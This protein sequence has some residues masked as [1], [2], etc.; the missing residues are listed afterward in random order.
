MPF[1]SPQV[2][3]AVTALV[4][5]LLLAATVF[6]PLGTLAWSHEYTVEQVKSDDPQLGETLAWTEQATS[7]YAENEA[8]ELFYSLKDNESQ[9][10][11]DTT[12]RAAQG[13]DQE[14]EL[15]IFPNSTQKFYQLQ[16]TPYENESIRVDL[17]SISDTTA[18]ELA[19]TPSSD[20]PQGVQN[21]VE[22]GQVRTDE[23]LSGYALWSHTRDIIA[24]DGTYYRQDSFTYRGPMFGGTDFH[25]LVILAVGAAL[26][27]RAGRVE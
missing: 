7:C 14:T 11:A 2:R 16:L 3:R 10:V 20:Y 5:L 1:D 25:R 17:T 9:V 26:C 13:G 6:A 21:L 22:K 8:C 27:Y 4:G 23:Q 15:I 19:S 12:Y 24:H 18:L